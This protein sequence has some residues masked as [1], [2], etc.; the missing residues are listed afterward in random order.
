MI[1][2]ANLAESETKALN[3]VLGP[4]MLNL[5]QFGNIGKALFTMN[6]NFC[7]DSLLSVKLQIPGLVN[8]LGGIAAKSKNPNIYI[9]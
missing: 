9:R 3:V 8:V 1:S 2:L 4:D 5:A 7:N 6:M